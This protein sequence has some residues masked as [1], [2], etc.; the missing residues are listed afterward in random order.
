MTQGRGITAH[1][2]SI[3]YIYREHAIAARRIG[4]VWVGEIWGERLTITL[5]LRWPSR[6]QALDAAARYVDLW[7]DRRDRRDVA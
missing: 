1:M 5:C 2:S 6:L 3:A 7:L 4:N